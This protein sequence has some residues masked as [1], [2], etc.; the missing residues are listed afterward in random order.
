MKQQDVFNKIGAILNELTEQYDY[1]KKD[2]SQLNELELELFVANAH[3]LMDHADILR[4]INAQA[5]ADRPALPQPETF[6]VNIEHQIE[7]PEPVF[8]PAPDIAPKA[9]LPAFE[10]IEP[11]KAAEF[12]PDTP[13]PLAEPEITAP[14]IIEPEPATEAEPEVPKP[15]IEQPAAVK[16]AEVHEQKFFEPVVQQL[17]PVV[18]NE[19]KDTPKPVEYI[20]DEE[21]TRPDD[22]T[23]IDADG[24]IRHEL[25]I[26]DTDD[27]WEEEEQQVDEPELFEEEDVI[28][29][30]A[31]EP[32]AEP[33]TPVFIP[34][35]PAKPVAVE[36]EPVKPAQ[37]EIPP[38]VI[39]QTIAVDDKK[40][41]QVFTINQR[42]S[43]Q[44][45][46]KS[47][48]VAAPV[49]D[50]KGAITLNDK[51]LY[52]QDLFNGYSLAYSEAIDILNRF[53]SFAEA[54][55]FLTTNYVTKNN[56]QSKPATAEKFY[57]LL[58][59]RYA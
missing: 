50:L 13:A 5:V 32:E 59:R 48:P 55:R 6:R 35:P 9:D 21:P 53:N 2:T 39:A 56:W 18:T 44:M 38:V 4:K 45:A 57:A 17:R 46:E 29:V 49:S 41:E 31:D 52:V 25:V 1:L 34:E 43:V 37:P 19:L 23:T 14:E 15:V 33:E 40:D 11:P 7:V 20:E 30:E 28:E 42:I 10:K 24:T 22:H 8:L 12:L 51:L 36:L 27:S 47:T 26:D 58:K 54:E 3:F 16:P